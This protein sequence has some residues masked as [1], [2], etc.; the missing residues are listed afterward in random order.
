LQ[1]PRLFIPRQGPLN[2]EVLGR[3]TQLITPT[4]ESAQVSIQEILPLFQS[5]LPLLLHTL[6]MIVYFSRY[7]ELRY[8]MHTSFGN[9][10][11]S[12]IE[13]FTLVNPYSAEL[14]Q[15]AHIN[16]RNAFKKDTEGVKVRKCG[17]L[18]CS[19]WEKEYREYSKCG[20]CKRVSYCSYVFFKKKF[21]KKFL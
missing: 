20:R 4:E 13:P 14:T 3:E 1:Q 10:V 16:M 19:H 2:R 5:K 9:N 8:A 12:F 15:L 6:K 7:Y 11:Y 18:S 21:Y 17:N